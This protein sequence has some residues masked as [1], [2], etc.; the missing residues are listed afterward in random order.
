MATFEQYCTDS[1]G[2]FGMMRHVTTKGTWESLVHDDILQE[3]E[4]IIQEGDVAYPGN[5]TNRIEMYRYPDHLGGDWIH[6]DHQ[7][8][9]FD[10]STLTGKTIIDAYLQMSSH[11]DTNILDAGMLVTVEI[12]YPDN[13]YYGLVRN[14]WSAMYAKIGEFNPVILPIG[15]LYNV[16]LDNTYVSSRFGYMFGISFRY[17]PDYLNIDDEE[18]EPLHSNTTAYNTTS[19]ISH[20]L[21]DLRLVINYEDEVGAGSKIVMM[22]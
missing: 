3:S 12:W 5:G 14:D 1:P 4:M 17:I 10:L 9:T 6:L 2:V 16:A 21:Y 11:S 22:V 19:P 20:N 18:A 15:T 7:Y 13:T 8:F